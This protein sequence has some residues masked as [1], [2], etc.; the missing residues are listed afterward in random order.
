VSFTSLPKFLQRHFFGNQTG[1][2]T[3]DLLTARVTY[4]FHLVIQSLHI[5]FS[6]SF[7]KRARWPSNRLSAFAINCR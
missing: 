5:Y 4:T 6:P 3:L 7:F 1:G 2:G